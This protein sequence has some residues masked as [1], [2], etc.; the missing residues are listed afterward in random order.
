MSSAERGALLKSMSQ[1]YAE[2]ERV[3]MSQVYGATRKD[4]KFDIDG[5]TGTLSYYQAGLRAW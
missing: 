2:R 3:T 5:A 4:S 1:L